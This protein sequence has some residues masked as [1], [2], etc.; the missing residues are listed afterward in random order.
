M[1]QVEL[2]TD[3]ACRG[4]PGPGGWGAILVYQGHEKELSGGERDTTNNR[5]ELMAAIRGL[6]ALKEPCKVTLTS[7]SVYLIDTI[8]KGWKKKKNT[9]LWERLEALL[10]M[11]DVS[12][13]WVKGHDG[14]PYN[15]RCDR[16]ATAAADA[17]RPTPE[18]AIP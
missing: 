5:M 7:D 12:F 10:R 16:L 2:Y 4:N 14:H 15:E 3:G 18:E 17:L 13:V 11:H 8:V 6:E 1:K 9:D